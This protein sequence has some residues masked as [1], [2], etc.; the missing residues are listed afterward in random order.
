MPNYRLRF[1][2]ETCLQ[3]PE[4]ITLT[5]G[6]QSVTFL[7][8]QKQVEE[9]AVLAQIDVEA[10]GAPQARQVASSS[11]LPPVLDA[12]AFA[13]STPLLLGSC[14]L[15]LKNERGSRNR[16]A[17]FIGERRVPTPTRLTLRSLQDAQR[18]LDSPDRPKLPLC[19]LRY[20]HHRQFPLERFV[21]SWLA[22]EELAG[23]ADISSTCSRCGIGIR[24]TECERPITHRGTNKERAWEL[25]SAANQ[26]VTR[27]EFNETI[28]G[29][30]RNSV[31][32]G[33]RYPEPVFLVELSQIA[34]RVQRACGAELSA[35]YELGER[36]TVDTTRPYSCAKMEMS[37][38]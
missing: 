10:P 8:S 11:L 14:E 24:C 38:G 9:R 25:F 2:V 29:R 7:F 34:N 30:A 5:F 35:R 15:T 17:N 19:W 4:D 26:D 12:L 6:G 27:S 37:S 1:R 36:P 31:F 20:C 28:W 33:S 18:V 13:S 22:L 3:H 23:D 16:R 21:F 32:H